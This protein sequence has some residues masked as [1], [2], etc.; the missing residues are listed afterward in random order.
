MPVVFLGE[1]LPLT[2]AGA[3]QASHLFPS[4][5]VMRSTPGTVTH[6]DM[7][8]AA[9]PERQEV[10]GGLFDSP[11]EFHTCRKEGRADRKL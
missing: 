5:P 4:Y 2:V 11:S 7:V 6:D 8:Y 3:A 10:G 1:D 9:L